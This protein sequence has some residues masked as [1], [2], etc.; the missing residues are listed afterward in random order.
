MK[1]YHKFSPS[2]FLSGGH[3]AICEWS[4]SC[5]SSL[6]F[7]SNILLLSGHHKF[8]VF[9]PLD[10]RFSLIRDLPIRRRRDNQVL[11]K[12]SSTPCNRSS[13][14]FASGLFFPP[15]NSS[16]EL[17]LSAKSLNKDKDSSSRKYI[18][19]SSRES[20]EARST[21]YTRKDFMFELERR[22]VLN[23]MRLSLRER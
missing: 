6:F 7:L 13:F 12:L 15:G 16:M 18:T 9:G 1:R 11:L 4:E 10:S 20:A 2:V 23:T 22:R 19:M 8:L 5:H 3:R 21:S 14:I 17:S